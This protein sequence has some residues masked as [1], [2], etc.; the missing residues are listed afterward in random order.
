MSGDKGFTVRIMAPV[1]V[2]VR[3]RNADSAV[4]IARAQLAKG[5]ESHAVGDA[6]VLVMW[7]QEDRSDE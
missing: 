2:R 3:A 4:D 6:E 1:E 7:A 5:G